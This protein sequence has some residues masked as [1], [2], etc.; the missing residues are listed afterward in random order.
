MSRAKRKA[1]REAFV[2]AQ[3]A[4][5]AQYERS[6][7]KLREPMRSQIKSAKKRGLKKFVGA[8]FGWRAGR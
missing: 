5:L 8:N 4:R 7:E 6:A 3:S 1:S 2:R